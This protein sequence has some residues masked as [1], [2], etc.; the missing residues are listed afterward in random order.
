M[1]DFTFYNP[2][3]ILFGRNTHKHIGAQL[4]AY[5][6]KKVLFLYGSGSIKHSGLYDAVVA[7]LEESGIDCVP[8]GGVVSNPVLS[9]TQQ[10]IELAKKEGVE[11]VLSVGGGSVLDEAKAVAAGALV[12]HDVWDFYLTTP[13]TQ[14]LP[15]FSILTLAASGSEMNG[16]SVLT[17]DSTQQ[18]FSFNAL[19]AYP[20]VSILNPELTFSVD[21]AY[22]AY[23]AVDAISHVIEGYFTQSGGAA[24]QDRLAETIILSVMESA[25]TLMEA[26]QD[27]NAR[28]QMMW[29]A[30]MALN[31]LPKNGLKDI[32]FPN[33]M[34]EHALSA[35][36]NIPH[37]AGLAIVIPAWMQW[38]HTQKPERFRRFA[39]EIFDLETP[40]EGIVALKTWFAALGAPTTLSQVGIAPKDLDALTSNAAQIAQMWGLSNEYGPKEIRTI[41][42]LA[43]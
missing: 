24:L 15:I 12:E 34:I 18:K 41:L 36:F 38:Y 22:T 33:H 9:H 16:N 40:M 26:P 13:I 8:F 11:A 25:N 2:T 6:I 42:E 43:L 28:A 32:N 5:G 19:D 29:A 4:Q 17:N 21:A 7:S 23:G 27:Y 10:A 37:G 1:H 30:T 31:G 20:K 14:A 39:K 3:K 35:L